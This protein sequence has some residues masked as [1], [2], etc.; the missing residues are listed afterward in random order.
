M[1]DCCQQQQQKQQLSS[2][3]PAQW[4][5]Q[6]SPPWGSISQRKLWLPLALSMSIFLDPRFSSN[7]LS[8]ALQ[9]QEDMG[10]VLCPVSQPLSVTSK[11]GLSQSIRAAITITNWVAHKQQ[12][13]L[14]HSSEAGK[15]KLQALGDSVSDEGSLSASQVVPSCCVLIGW[16]GQHS[17]LEPLLKGH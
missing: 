2:T 7:P 3:L 5:L 16:K 11:T 9:Y 8:P 14:C 13:R 15:F 17:S 6:T 10:Q 12:K 4:I 1:N